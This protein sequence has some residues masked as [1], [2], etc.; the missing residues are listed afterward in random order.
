MENIKD[1]IA[2]FIL[3]VGTI[4]VVGAVWLLF[5]SLQAGIPAMVYIIG[6]SIATFWALNRLGG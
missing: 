1:F 5:T 3:G 6:G 2:Y 4:I